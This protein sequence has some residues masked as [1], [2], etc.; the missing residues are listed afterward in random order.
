MN[1]LIFY[2]LMAVLWI[3]YLLIRLVKL[4]KRVGAIEKVASVKDFLKHAGRS[5]RKSKFSLFS[6]F[7]VVGALVSSGCSTLPRAVRDCPN[8]FTDRLTTSI[9]REDAKY[10]SIL[11]LYP[12]MKPGI[13]EEI[14]CLTGAEED[15]LEKSTKVS[16]AFYNKATNSMAHMFLDS[17]ANALM[18]I[19]FAPFESDQTKVAAYLTV[20]FPLDEIMKMFTKKQDRAN[21][22]ILTQAQGLLT[23]EEFNDLVFELSGDKFSTAK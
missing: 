19:V 15:T 16:V 17:E 23:V 6:L 4:E 3:A 8:T 11:Y 7:L 21:V 2:D 5:Q 14:S 18:N 9:D 22:M 20:Y 13:D 1:D 12:E 10:E